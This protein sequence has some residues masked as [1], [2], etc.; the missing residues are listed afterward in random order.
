MEMND[1]EIFI[2]IEKSSDQ[3]H[4]SLLVFKVCFAQP[5]ILTCL[6]PSLSLHSTHIF[7]I[8]GSDFKKKV[9]ISVKQA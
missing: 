4:S 3:G 1:I 2:N 5:S 7:N 8:Q 6:R 9:Y